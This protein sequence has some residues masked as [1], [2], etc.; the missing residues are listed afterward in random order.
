[1]RDAPNV[2]VGAEY[3]QPPSPNSPL[4]QPV[5][6]AN[7]TR[8][9][10]RPQNSFL[11]RFG[12][13]APPQSPDKSEPFLLIDPQP[14]NNKELPPP[15]PLGPTSSTESAPPGTNPEFGGINR[16]TSIMKKMG[17]VVRGN[18]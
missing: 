11:G 12:G 1:M 10:H 8:P 4:D 17:R 13:K 2:P 15:P 18:R 9:T 6:S 7:P 16:K 3:E 5:T 14:S